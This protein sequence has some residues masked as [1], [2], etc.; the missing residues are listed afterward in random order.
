MTT[1]AWPTGIYPRACALRL[2]TF[3]RAALSPYSGSEQVTDMLNDRWYMSITLPPRAGRVRGAQVEAFIAALRG[4]TNTVNL[5]HFARPEPL[6]TL[7][8]ATCGATSAGV[9]SLTLTGSG[10]LKAGDLFGVS[11]QL[12]QVA[13]DVTLSGA[14]AVS[15]VNRVR[16]AISGG[17]A[18][19]LTRPTAPFR[20]MSGQ[21]SVNWVPGH[22]EDVSLDFAEVITP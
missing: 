18:V 16:A 14:T 4:M 15:V 9:L 10:T 13:A 3:Q 6:G 21:A 20:L 8:S 22:A 2:G 17:T 1:I 19:T 5:W 12:F 7:T 11:G